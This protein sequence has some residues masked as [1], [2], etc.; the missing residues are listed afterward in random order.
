[1][2]AMAEATLKAVP[3]RTTAAVGRLTGLAY[4]RRSPELRAR[5]RE[6]TAA[7]YELGANGSAQW[8]ISA[9]YPCRRSTWSV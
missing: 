5:V 3:E 4:A 2:R 7:S 9:S 8:E 1:M 6:V